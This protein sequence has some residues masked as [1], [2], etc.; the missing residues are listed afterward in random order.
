M[1]NNKLWI[2]VKTTN[3][4]KTMVV[5]LYPI[6]QRKN[7]RTYSLELAANL[8]VFE[9]LWKFTARRPK[10]ITEELRKRL[11]AAHQTG[12]YY[13]SIC[14][15]FGLQRSP[16]GQTVYKW[17]KLKMIAPHSGVIE[18]HRS[19]RS[20]RKEPEGFQNFSRWLPYFYQ[21]MVKKTKQKT[22]Q[23]SSITFWETWC[24]SV[25]FFWVGG[26]DPFWISREWL[27][28]TQ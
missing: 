1:S 22:T 4:I 23:N 13:N 11:V 12:K 6:R 18:Q 7:K 3:P 21:L 19:Q 24:G 14:K 25:A 16:F 27:G 15:V 8:D 26:W 2:Y 20:K 17:R 28:Q 5:M 9:S 10:D